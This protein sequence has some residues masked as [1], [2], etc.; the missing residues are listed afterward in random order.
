MTGERHTFGPPPPLRGRS[1]AEGRRE[2]GRPP[3]HRPIPKLQRTRAKSLRSDMTDAEHCL[4]SAL[5]AHRLGG[6]SFRR[7]TL[8]GRFIVDFVCHEKHLV[9]EVDGGQH[10]ENA[11]DV[12]RDR[13]LAS[14][15]YRV[16][17][18][19]NHDVLRNRNGVLE[20]IVAAAAEYTPLPNPPPQG[21]MGQTAPSI[22]AKP[23][24][25]PP[26]S[27]SLPRKGGGNPNTATKRD[28][29]EESQP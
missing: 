24:L 18:F 25:Q 2:G 21:G 20:M 16:L 29:P 4:W 11:R 13:W 12:E 17:R 19:W 28:P 9:I 5:R 6:L 8:I 22:P 10:A 1:G 27:L 26:P 14:K 23:H 3:A 7:Q 15:S